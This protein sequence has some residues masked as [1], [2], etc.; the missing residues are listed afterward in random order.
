MDQMTSMTACAPGVPGEFPITR[1][2]NHRQVP[3]FSR[4]ISAGVGYS[5]WRGANHCEQFASARALQGLL[6]FSHDESRKG[7][8]L[9]LGASPQAPMQ[10]R[11]NVVNLNLR[12]GTHTRNLPI[13]GSKPLLRPFQGSQGV[14]SVNAPRRAAKF[15]RLQESFLPSAFRTMVPHPAPGTAH[16][17]RSGIEAELRS[18][19]S[20][21]SPSTLRA[22]R[23]HSSACGTPQ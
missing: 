22:T 19:S 1:H 4:R 12:L 3:R 8:S 13:T 6:E 14:T 5:H 18:Q 2:Q 17:R 11:R 16:E 15:L 23:K 21:A 10:R 9:R 20:P 7:T